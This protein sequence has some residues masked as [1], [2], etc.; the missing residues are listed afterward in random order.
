MKLSVFNKKLESLQNLL[1]QNA[2]EENKIYGVIGDTY[3]STH[4]NIH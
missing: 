1:I 3:P 4:I 2:S